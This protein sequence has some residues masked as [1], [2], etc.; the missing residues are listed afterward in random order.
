[1]TVFAKNI[2]LGIVSIVFVVSCVKKT[3]GPKTLSADEI[4]KNNNARA[5]EFPYSARTLFRGD[6]GRWLTVNIKSIRLIN[7]TLILENAPGLWENEN[8]SRYIDKTASF[9]LFDHYRNKNEDIKVEVI[10]KGG[11]FADIILTSDNLNEYK[12][13]L[14]DL[15]IPWDHLDSWQREGA[16]HVF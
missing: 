14:M 2:F 15:S 13:V 16:R 8:L 7:D 1:M 3:E 11:G 5:T 12:Y 6:N 10:E 9:V 4:A